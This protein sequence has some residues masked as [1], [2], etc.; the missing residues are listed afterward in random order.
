VT[1]RLGMR[2]WLTFFYSVICSYQHAALLVSGHA[3]VHVGWP[4]PLVRTPE[5]VPRTISLE[6]KTQYETGLINKE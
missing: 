3:A 5:V 6:T 4:P 1:S 2:K